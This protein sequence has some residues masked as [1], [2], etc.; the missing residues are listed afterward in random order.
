MGLQDRMM[1]LWRSG[2]VAMGRLGIWAVDKGGGRGAEAKRED[3]TGG[4]APL[5]WMGWGAGGRPEG[6]RWKDPTVGCSISHKAEGTAMLADQVESEPG[7][8]LG[9]SRNTHW[10]ECLAV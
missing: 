4:Y 6:R 7:Q 2:S 3:R 9:D 8:G 10:E 5:L 1:E